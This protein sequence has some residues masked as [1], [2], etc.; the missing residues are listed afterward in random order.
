MSVSSLLWN[1][2]IGIAEHITRIHWMG[3]AF[4]IPAVWG[5]RMDLGKS[6]VIYVTWLSILARHRTFTS[7][8]LLQVLGTR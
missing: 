6:T 7:K 4:E 5:K 8:R 2:R 1:R 3:G